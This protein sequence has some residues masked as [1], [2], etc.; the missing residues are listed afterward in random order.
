M[1]DWAEPKFAAAIG[2]HVSAGKDAPAADATGLGAIAPAAA[3][4]STTRR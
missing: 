2:A 4:P 1:L 3:S